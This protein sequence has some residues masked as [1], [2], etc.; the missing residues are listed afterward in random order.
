MSLE[1]FVPIILMLVLLLVGVPVGFSLLISSTF[2]LIW[3]MGWGPATGIMRGALYSET[4]QLILTTI[5]MF[6]LM[7]EFLRESGIT[8]DIYVMLNSWLGHIRGGLAVATALANGGMAALTGSSTATV[9][10]LS[11]IAVPEMRKYGYGDQLSVGTV[12]AAGTFASLIPPSIGLILIGVLT[13]QSISDL[14]IAAIIPGLLTIFFYVILILVWSNYDH[15]MS[16]EMEIKASWKER[17]GATLVVW[18]AVLLVILVLGGIYTGAVTPTEAGAVGA[19]GAFILLLYKGGRI[20]EI[21]K[22][23][24]SATELTAM[25]FVVLLG[26]FLFGSYMSATGAIGVLITAVAGAPVPRLIIIAAILLMYIAAGT[27]MSV[28][29]VIIVTLPVVWP[30]MVDTWGYDPIWM[31][32]VLIKV[33]EFGLITPPLGLNVYVAVSTID[34]EVTS[35]FRGAVKFL[36]ADLLVLAIL[37]AYPPIVMILL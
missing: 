32:I 11:S 3:I 30:L 23:G 17:T 20:E 6:I 36:L 9:A 33:I 13:E 19:T 21:R 37:V 7:A 16:G 27:M 28:L 5:P 10:A 29:A 25:I 14:F 24:R 34:V 15:D 12:A 2:G 1:L 18:P 8:T 31:G 4:A 26:A 22:A 35:A